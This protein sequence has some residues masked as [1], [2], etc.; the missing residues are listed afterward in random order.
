MPRA[1]RASLSIFTAVSEALKQNPDV[2]KAAARIRQAE[3]VLRESRALFLPGISLHF[4]YL[5]ADRPSAFLF[6]T[7]DAREFKP[8]TDFN[9]PG[10]FDNFETALSLQY[11]LFRGGRD[12]LLRRAAREG[13]AAERARR[14]AVE[15]G[16]IASVIRAYYEVLAATEFIKTA[17]AS[18]GTVSAQL[19]ETRVKH[20][21]GSALRSDVLSLE[22]RLAEARER[23][24][25]ARN[26]RSL[27]LAAFARLLGLPAHEVVT[28]SGEE[29]TP[30]EIPSR[31]EKALEEALMKRPELD[32]VRRLLKQ[33]A[34]DVS[35]R[36][37]A[38]LPRID[39]AGDVRFDDPDLRY[40]NHDVN[41]TVGVMLRWDLF[42]GGGRHARLQKA[43]ALMEELGAVERETILLIQLDVKRA[44]LNLEAARARLEVARAGVAQ[45]EETLNLM[46]KQFDGGTATSAQYLNAELAL[47]D[48]RVRAT[49]ARFD[50]KQAYADA[51]R[52]MGWCEECA[53]KGARP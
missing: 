39:F 3:A 48:A 13:L 42:L 52:A 38:Y 47:T 27:A 22:V 37:R 25:R 40:D 36:R 21:G 16:L 32:R 11:N 9:D 30:R 28:L 20:E 7:I 19:R 4:D 12:L 41:W 18:V 33:A 45:A 53:Q 1:P 46:K 2:E 17:E 8:G 51:A 24:I 44:Y 10:A 34:L 5:R 14:R 49:R 29:W 50:M 43:E 15:N 26:S 31:Y 6:K 35:I 23:L